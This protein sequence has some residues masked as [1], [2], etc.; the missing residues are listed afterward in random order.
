MAGGC[1]S[2]ASSLV[3]MMGGVS[4]AAGACGLG[5]RLERIAKHADLVWHRESPGARCVGHPPD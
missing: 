3:V 5:G 4:P 2:G 1:A